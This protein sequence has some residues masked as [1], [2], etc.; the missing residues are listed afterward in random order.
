MLAS[1]P[2]LNQR[3]RQA[4]I[5]APENVWRTMVVDSS[6]P[7]A[8]PSVFITM[9]TVEATRAGLNCCRHSMERLTVAPSATAKTAAR[10]TDIRPAS[11]SVQSRPKGA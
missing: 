10:V 3:S 1:A 4:R 5:S 9:S 6:A 7:P 8:V 11:Q 2:C